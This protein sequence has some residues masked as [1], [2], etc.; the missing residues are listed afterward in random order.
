VRALESLLRRLLRHRPALSGGDGTK[1]LVGVRDFEEHGSAILARRNSRCPECGRA[2]RAGRSRI[3]RLPVPLTPR[4]WNA[5]DRR[6][7]P[8]D[9]LPGRW[10]HAS[11]YASASARLVAQQKAAA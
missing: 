1:R 4:P 2:I 6:G 9:P 5:G 8:V 3:K 11:C 10:V 7:K